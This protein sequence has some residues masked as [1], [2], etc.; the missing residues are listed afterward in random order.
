M[1]CHTLKFKVR[2][3]T[4]LRVRYH[5]KFHA[6]STATAIFEKTARTYSRTY[7]SATHKFIT[8]LHAKITQTR[9]NTFSRVRS[10]KRILVWTETSTVNNYRIKT[11]TCKLSRVM[12]RSTS[13]YTR[14]LH[15]TC[16]YLTSWCPKWERHCWRVD[17]WNGIDAS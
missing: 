9:N 10:L 6:R 11:S 8:I 14:W 16:K 15:K 13:F 5:S 1:N 12:F 4:S 7:W 3:S 2:Y 17:V